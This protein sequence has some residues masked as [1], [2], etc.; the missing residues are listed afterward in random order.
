M[1]PYEVHCGDSYIPTILVD[2]FVYSTHLP[3][4]P[5]RDMQGRMDTP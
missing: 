5:K 3:T 1:R 4:Y 2:E